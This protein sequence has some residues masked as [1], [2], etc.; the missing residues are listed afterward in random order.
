MSGFILVLLLTACGENNEEEI[1]EVTSETITTLPEERPEDF[2]FSLWYGI[3]G[4]NEI[5]TYEGTY[6][7]DLAEGGDVTTELALTN[8]EMNVIYEQMRSVDILN[9]PRYVSTTTCVHPYDE[10][11]L[12][13]TVNGEVI[14]R[15]W[16]HAMCGEPEERL[17]E[18]VEIIHQEMIEPRSEY[19]NLPEAT[20]GYD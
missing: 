20:G 17:A 18:L 16:I 13:M 1:P 8:E 12:T 2:D 19:Q 10:N 6:T 11:H 15:E 7:K 3:T 14:E 4:A 9:T 5:N